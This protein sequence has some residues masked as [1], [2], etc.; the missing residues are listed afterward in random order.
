MGRK[1]ILAAAILCSICIAGIS[2][3]SAKDWVWGIGF[4]GGLSRLE[5]DLRHPRISPLLSGH[6]RALPTP[7]LAISGELGFAALTTARHPNPLFTDFKTIIIPFELSTIFNFLPFRKVNPYVFLGGGGVYWNATNNGT[8]VVAGGRKQ[9]GI[10]SFLKTGGGL[11]FKVSRN[12]GL[13]V[14]ATFRYSFTDAFDQLRFGDENDQVV[15]VHAGFT[16]YFRATKDKDRDLIPDELDLMPEIAEDRDG[17]LDHDGIPEKNPNLIAMSGSE[18]IRIDDLENSSPIVV[19]HLITSAES[20]RDIIVEATVY[21][22]LE[23]RSVAV[24][25]R[26]D[27]TSSWNVASMDEMRESLYQGVI[28]GV[29]VHGSGLEYCVV[30]VDETLRG[31]GYSGLPSRP[32]NVDI[33]NNGKG[34]RILGGTAGAAAIGTASYLILRKQK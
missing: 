34:W 16:Y 24:L 9:D 29:A 17:Y 21:S 5:G 20:G 13:S 26:S 10:D 11:E 1:T 4:S 8:T 14:G 12:L 15:D 33:F 2:D 28:P 22:A 3:V 19:H 18:P 23:L 32:I 6:L 30:A 25:Y 31:I 7:S 27:G